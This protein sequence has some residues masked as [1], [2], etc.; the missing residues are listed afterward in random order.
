MR[1]VG[2]M[3][4]EMVN[5]LARRMVHIGEADDIASATAKVYDQLGL[6]PETLNKE[7]KP[8]PIQYEY[9]VQKYNDIAQ[10]WN[11]TKWLVD[12]RGGREWTASEVQAV[13]WVRFQLAVGVVPDSHWSALGNNVVDVAFDFIPERSLP[14]RQQFGESL[15]SLTPEQRDY[16]SRNVAYDIADIIQ[17]ETGVTVLRKQPGWG[18]HEGT[19]SANT[20]YSLAGSPAAIDTALDT[21]SLLTQARAVYATTQPGKLV[22]G[23][24]N[25]PKTGRHWGIDFIPDVS[26]VR[27]MESLRLWLDEQREFYWEGSMNAMDPASM[28]TSLR[29]IYT[30]VAEKSD[31][32]AFEAAAPVPDSVMARLADGSWAKEMGIE[33]PV[34]VTI[35]RRLH[36]VKSRINDYDGDEQ[37]ALARIE[38]GEDSVKVY[39]EEMGRAVKEALRKRGKDDVRERVAGRHMDSLTARADESIKKANERAHSVSRGAIN[40]RSAADPANMVR[41]QYSPRGFRGATAYDRGRTTAEHVAR[42]QLSGRRGTVYL[43]TGKAD[44]TT[45]VHEVFHLFAEDLDPSAIKSIHEAWWAAQGV[46]A[47]RRGIAQPTEHNILVREAE[48]WAAAQFEEWTATG[49]APSFDP[50]L[51]AV[52]QT[53]AQY[54]Q[55][56]NPTKT[57]GLQIDPTVQGLFD[58]LVPDKHRGPAASFNVDEYRWM[59]AARIALQRAEDE[60]FRVHYYKRGRGLL[61]R[62]INHPYLGMYPAS[63][64]WGKVLPELMRF[65][66][67]Q[68]FGVDAPFAGMAMANHVYEALQ[69]QMNTDGGELADLIGRFPEALRFIQLMVPGTPWDIPVNAPAWTRRLVQ[70]AWSNKPINPGAAITDTVAYAFGPGRVPNDVGKFIS[71]TFG[72]TQGLGD[73]LG[74]TYETKAEEAERAE[75]ER[76]LQMRGQ[77]PPPTV[78]QPR[79]NPDGV[80]Q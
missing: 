18:N 61:E 20:T 71:Q 30:D 33:E 7:G 36:N 72:F 25:S 3:D 17:E 56:L 70:D 23:Y 4:L 22:G 43:K 38:A 76:L 59:E 31:L 80:I 35:E 46:P 5:Y 28:K 73:I 12:E 53:Y 14:L 16:V 15:A 13:D 65:L 58:S 57:A 50:T 29:S 66:V 32:A 2:F 21:I 47:A 67:K 77:M 68:P 54:W 19:V 9:I 51:N 1:A 60:A 10:E 27:T 79:L 48:E 39:D 8:T 6:T 44:V 37:R 45:P 55:A 26:D 63:Y 74:G 42:G 24:T 34:P 41:Q 62:S 52:F 11:R 69:L 75:A 40:V 78:E 64:M 49:I